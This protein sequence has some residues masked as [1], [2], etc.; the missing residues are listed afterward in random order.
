VMLSDGTREPRRAKRLFEE[1][2]LTLEIADRAV[3]SCRF[4]HSYI[5]S[6]VVD[7]PCTDIQAALFAQYV[8]RYLGLCSPISATSSSLMPATFESS[9]PCSRDRLTRMN[10]TVINA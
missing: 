1:G 2:L 3:D 7:A 8:Y 9:L 10:Q 6:R 5:R 4:R